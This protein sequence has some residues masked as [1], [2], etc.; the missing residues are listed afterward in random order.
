MG[1]Q[2]ADARRPSAFDP[3]GQFKHDAWATLGG[4]SAA[5]ARARYADVL[6][7][8]ILVG[9]AEEALAAQGGYYARVLASDA[10]QPFLRRVLAPPPG[11]CA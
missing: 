2:P 5:E 11:A 1:P 10:P 3:A 8:V 6:A 9:H 7:L 4:M